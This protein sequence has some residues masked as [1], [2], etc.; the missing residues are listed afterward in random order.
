MAGWT[1]ARSAVNSVVERAGLRVENLAVHWAEKMAGKLGPP[2][3]G[4]RVVRLVDH[5]AGSTVDLRAA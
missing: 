1:A 5:W 4:S 2:M 3:V